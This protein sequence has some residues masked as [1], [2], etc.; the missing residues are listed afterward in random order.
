M[1]KC[2]VVGGAGF[3]GSAVGWHILEDTDESVINLDA[4]IYADNLESIPGVGVS[5][6]YAFAQVDICDFSALSGFASTFVMRF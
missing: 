2:L 5:G 3:I 6:S 4:L 1:K